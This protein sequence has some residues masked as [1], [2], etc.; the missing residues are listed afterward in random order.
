[1]EIV[2]AVIGVVVLVGAALTWRGRRTGTALARGPVSTDLVRYEA[3]DGSSL[4][5]EPLSHRPAQ[6]LPVPRAVAS[7]LVH[8]ATKLAP[9][10]RQAARGGTKQLY[11]LVHVPPGGLDRVAGDPS[12]VRGFGREGGRISGHAKFKRVPAANVTPALALTVASAALGAYWQQQL[13]ARLRGIETSLEGIRSRLD[14]ELDA[15]LD[16][17]ERILAEHEASPPPGR[18]EPPSAVTDG[19]HANLVERRELQAL[20]DKLEPLE[21]QRLPHRDY[22]NQVLAVDGER[23]DLHVYRALRGLAVELRVLRLKRLGGLLEPDAYHQLLDRQEDELREQLDLIDN[24]LGTALSIDGSRRADRRRAEL[25]Q[26][27]ERRQQ[28]ELATTLERRGHLAVLSEVTGKMTDA[29]PPAGFRD[30]PAELLLEID[31]DRT[32]VYALPSAEW[33]ADNGDQP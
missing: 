17:A 11:R 1:M 6:T 24:L 20:V 23:L 7:E 32:D 22:H 25:P 14:A 26:R 4:L 8:E 9:Q 33:A 3:A 21:G 13:D 16:L 5:L 27:R 30:G 15:S 29:L 18:Y 12:L 28:R 19:L 10:L 2:I 31:Q